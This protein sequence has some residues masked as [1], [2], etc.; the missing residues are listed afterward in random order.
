MRTDRVYFSVNILTIIFLDI[1]IAYIYQTRG[2]VEYRL[3]NFPDL[4]KFII[5][6]RT[7]C[8][9]HNIFSAF[10]TSDLRCPERLTSRKNF[11]YLDFLSRSG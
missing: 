10:K 4:A 7:A 8:A 5:Y 2:I 3:L 9:C 6:L 1:V 11:N